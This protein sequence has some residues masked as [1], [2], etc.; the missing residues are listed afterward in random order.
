MVSGFPTYPL[1]GVFGSRS[2]AAATLAAPV[3]L[4]LAVRQLQ[5]D[6]VHAPAT[7]HWLSAE[8]SAHEGSDRSGCVALGVTVI[9]RGRSS[10]AILQWFRHCGGPADAAIT[11]SHSS[12]RDFTRYTHLPRWLLHVT[13]P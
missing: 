6:I 2:Y 7:T 10:L 1:G 9:A 3:E 5:F 8:T 13:H 12:A 11:I 4:G